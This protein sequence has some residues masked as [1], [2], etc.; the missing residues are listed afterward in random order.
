[1]ARRDDAHVRSDHHIIG[2]VQPAKVIEGAIL[3][4]EASRLKATTTNRI[5][6]THGFFAYP[7][8]SLCHFPSVVRASSG[9]VRANAITKLKTE[10]IRPAMPMIRIIPEGLHNPAN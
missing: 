9:D 3:I 5:A 2:N 6:D 4:Y 8:N 10:T 7:L 1:M